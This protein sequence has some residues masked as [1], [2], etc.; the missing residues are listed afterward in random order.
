MG[1][2]VGGGRREVSGFFFLNEGWVRWV[3][4]WVGG[5][6][7]AEA[8]HAPTGLVVCVGASALAALPV[9]VALFVWVGGWVD[10]K[11]ERGSWWEDD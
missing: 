10:G 6:T 11:C 7:G 4:G 9:H 8:I 1:G 5:R 3:G 2:W